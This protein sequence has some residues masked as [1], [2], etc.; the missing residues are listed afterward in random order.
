MTF[1]QIEYFLELAEHK[2]FTQAAKVCFSTQPNLSRQ[3]VKLEEELGCQ[4]FIRDK[5]SHSVKLTIAREYFQKQCHKMMGIYQQSLMELQNLETLEPIR[6]GMMNGISP[7]FE[8]MKR[9]KKSNKY[10]NLQIL[11]LS[12]E[13][14]LTEEQVDICFMI[15][16][17]ET[18][19]CS[20]HL[21]HMKAPMLV[22]KTLCS[23]KEDI[24]IEN[25][26]SY[27]FSLPIGNAHGPVM[28]YLKKHGLKSRSFPNIIFD[29][30]SYLMDLLLNNSIGFLINDNLEKYEKDFFI[31]DNPEF[32]VEIPI[33][34][35]WNPS[36]HQI[37]TKLAND[38]M[39]IYQASLL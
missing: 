38:I 13:R 33:G 17:E 12:G 8:I 29:F 15:M 5:Q 25:L 19:P 7:L 28:D 31:M 23:S 37:C 34:I 14:Y 1:R 39:D 27:P 10:T 16:P 2:T 35:K 21:Y 32:T 18:S 24:T 36:K 26:K 22:P 3:I 6:F 30:E 4:L 20:M 9:L 11:H